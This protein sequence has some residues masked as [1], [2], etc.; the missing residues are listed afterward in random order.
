MEL[1]FL[2]AGIL[3]GSTFFIYSHVNNPSTLELPLGM[4]TR[5]LDHPG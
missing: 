3:G 4:Y 2:L 1:L 5:Q